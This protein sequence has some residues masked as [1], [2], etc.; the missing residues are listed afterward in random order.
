MNFLWVF[1]RF[2]T[3][4]GTCAFSEIVLGHGF[5]ALLAGV[6]ERVTE[7][8]STVLISGTTWPELTAWHAASPHGLRAES[9]GNGQ[10]VQPSNA[11]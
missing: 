10:I 3:Q 7:L 5:K 8:H 9:P 1:G 4:T 11:L 6:Q 2:L